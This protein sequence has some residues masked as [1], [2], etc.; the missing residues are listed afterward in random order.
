MNMDPILHASLAVQIHVVVAFT[1]LVI[2][3]AMWRRKK[4][5]PSHKILGRTFV[6]FMLLTAI[7]AI[8]IRQINNGQFSFI[9]LFVPLTFIGTFQAIY[10]IRKRNIKKHVSAVRGMFFGALLI[11]G[12]LSFLPGRTLWHV[13]FG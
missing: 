13:F 8:F 2:G 7:S 3:I 11:P 4:G 6:G 1:A 9:H 12:F 5:T 10:W